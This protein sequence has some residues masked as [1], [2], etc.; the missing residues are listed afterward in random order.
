M[1]KSLKGNK[2]KRDFDQFYGESVTLCDKR[3]R[4]ISILLRLRSRNHIQVKRRNQPV[5][6]LSWFIGLSLTKPNIHLIAWSVLKCSWHLPDCIH[7]AD[8]CAGFPEW[9]PRGSAAL[10]LHLRNPQRALHHPSAFSWAICGVGP[11]QSQ[12]PHVYEFL[13]AL[14]AAAPGRRSVSLVRYHVTCFLKKETQHW[15]MTLW[16][17]VTSLSAECAWK[18][19]RK[20][21]FLHKVKQRSRCHPAWGA[22]SVWKWE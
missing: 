10:T 6:P 13:F 12:T 1:E 2:K 7:S 21:A 4:E 20:D 15:D 16:C 14:P 11:S 3:N 9:L 8:V 22:Q 18:K 19:H 5:L 17:N